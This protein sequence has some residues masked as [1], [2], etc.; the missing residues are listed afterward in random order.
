[1]FIKKLEFDKIFYIHLSLLS[2]TSFNMFTVN[3]EY[4][5][6]ECACPLNVKVEIQEQNI[7]LFSR[8]YGSWSYLRRFCLCSNSVIYKFY[9]VHVRRVCVT[10]YYSPKR[11]SLINRE[12]GIKKVGSIRNGRSMSCDEIREYFED[13]AAY[14]KRKDLEECIIHRKKRTSVCGLELIWTPIV[15]TR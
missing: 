11:P 9:G 4:T 12:H 8:D 6:H 2:Y 1:M 7:K 5:C 10:C 13:F 14:R 3:W 15:T